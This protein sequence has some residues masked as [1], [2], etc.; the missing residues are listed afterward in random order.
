MITDL[1]TAAIFGL[2]F[3][4]PSVDRLFVAAM[5]GGLTLV[6]GTYLSGLEGLA[7]YVSA[8]VFDLTI[9]ALIAAWPVATRLAVDLQRISVASIV[10]NMAGYVSWLVYWPHHAYDAAFYALYSVAIFVLLRGEPADVG[11]HTRDRGRPGIH[12][13]TRS[14]GAHFTQDGGKI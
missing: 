2:V 9:V 4:Q 10:L 14:G 3:V 11:H 1:L 7:Y 6:H 8:A 5:F 13:G 12:R